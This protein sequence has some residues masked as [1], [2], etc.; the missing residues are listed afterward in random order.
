MGN[1]VVILV[2]GALGA[3]ARA[4]VAHWWPGQGSLP[5]VYVLINLS[6]AF[7][8]G[9]VMTWS[10][11]TMRLGERGRLFGGVGFLGGYTTFSTWMLGTLE[12]AGHGHWPAAA[13]YLTGCLLLGPAATV[14]GIAL[15][16]AGSGRGTRAASTPL[17]EAE[18]EPA[19]PA[20]G[21]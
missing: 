12:L 13:A 2:G 14:A 21:S 1:T 19:P 5:W 3:L 8:I 11:E 10:L 6:G 4:A 20:Q 7:A 18:P 15:G 9:L 16:R 17:P